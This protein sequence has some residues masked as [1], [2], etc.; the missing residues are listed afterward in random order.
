ML[1]DDVTIK[2]QAGKGGKGGVYFNSNL[3]SLGPTGGRGGNG[4]NV[5]VEGVSDLGALR[6]FRYKKEVFAEDG[7]NGKKKLNDGT[8]GEDV[9]LKVPVGTVL[10]NLD[11]NKKKEITKVGEKILIAAG[12]F[13]GHG[14]YH[15]RSGKNT[16]PRQFQPGLPGE[17]FVLRMELKLIADV[18]LIGYP[19]AGKSSLLNELT[20]AKSKVANYP[21]TTLEPNLGV[22]YDLVLADIPGLIEGASSGK[23]LG[24]KFLRH[25][26]RTKILFHLISSESD[27]P[28]KDYYAVI[29]E[30]MTYNEELL[31]K[32]EYIF[33]AKSDLISEKELKGK[34]MELKKA[35]KPVKAVSIHDSKS[36][37][38]VKKILNKLAEDKKIK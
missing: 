34:I 33:L 3:M 13:G 10:H 19:N 25:I 12:G 4:G 16:S 36:L 6:Q 26:E 2:V 7:E 1:I 35:G 31:K 29:K 30:L 9:I 5:Y 24:I 20:A 8:A 28:L 37:D 15:F 17:A 32:P 22:Y 18:G 38:E 14:N 11:E 21:F 27:D 23:G